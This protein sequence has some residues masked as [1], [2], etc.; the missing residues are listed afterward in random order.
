MKRWVFALAL[1]AVF[2]AAGIMSLYVGTPRDVS[3]LK[4]FAGGKVRVSGQLVE[5]G[6]DGDYLYLILRGRDGF[7]IKAVVPYQEVLKL[8]GPSFTF[9]DEVVVEGV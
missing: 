5:Y 6:K 8:A 4:N 1:S 9:S 2:L 7:T 3:D